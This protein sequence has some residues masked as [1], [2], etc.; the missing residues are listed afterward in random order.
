MGRIKGSKISEETKQ[1]MKETWERKRN[2][3]EDNLDSLTEKFV[4]Q[5]S[6]IK[7]RPKKYR[8]DKKYFHID[9]DIEEIFLKFVDEECIDRSR[10]IS[11]LI[12]NYLKEK[13]LI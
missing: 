4:K 5:K 2:E 13:G 7:G 1:K 9:N 10:F 11:K 3:K 6:K 12:R 8:D